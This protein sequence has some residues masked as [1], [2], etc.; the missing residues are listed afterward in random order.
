MVRVYTHTVKLI[1]YEEQL[2]KRLCAETGLSYSGILR[3]GLYLVADG[4]KLG[5]E[6]GAAVVERM[7]HV[8]Q[9]ELVWSRRELE[10]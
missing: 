6:T 10:S 7:R 5:E 9:N 1:E 2:L 3:A 4:Q 8:L